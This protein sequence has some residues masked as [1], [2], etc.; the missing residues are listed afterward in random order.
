MKA[1][2]IDLKACLGLVLP[3]Q[4]C[5]I[6]VWEIWG[7]FS[8]DFTSWATPTSLSSLLWTPIVVHDYRK[9]ATTCAMLHFHHRLTNFQQRYITPLSNLFLNMVTI[10][11]VD[12]VHY[13]WL[14]INYIML[15]NFPSSNKINCAI[16]ASL[17][18]IVTIPT[19]NRY[20]PQIQTR[21]FLFM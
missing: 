8:G 19:N 7:W 17:N 2:R 4:Y 11:P 6:V 1:F 18:Y 15:Q 16:Q 9:L 10:L 14:D 21:L 3:N 5:P 12:V 13:N 20:T